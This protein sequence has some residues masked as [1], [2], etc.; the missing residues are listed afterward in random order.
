MPGSPHTTSLRAASA[1]AMPCIHYMHV[2]CVTALSSAV[3]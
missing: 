1:I 3:A 2:S